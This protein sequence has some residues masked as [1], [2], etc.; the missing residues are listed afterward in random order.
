MGI[1][2][3]KMN[4]SHWNANWNCNSLLQSNKPSF[5]AVAAKMAKKVWK[6]EMTTDGRTDKNVS[7]WSIVRKA[8]NL[9][10]W[11][12]IT[13]CLLEKNSINHYTD[14]IDRWHYIGFSTWQTL[15]SIIYLQRSIYYL[16]LTLKCQKISSHVCRS[17]QMWHLALSDML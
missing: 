3:A 10:V 2:L 6:T 5:N 4:Q 13:H 12:V 11:V 8:D 7:I 17:R 16:F 1:T 14:L 15:F 9:L